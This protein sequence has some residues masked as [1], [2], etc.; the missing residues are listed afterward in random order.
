MSVM[1]KRLTLTAALL[2]AAFAAVAPGSASATVAC[3]FS[4]GALNIQSDSANDLPKIIRSGDNIVVQN[5]GTALSCGGQPTVHNTHVIAHQDVSSG[6]G[7]FIVDLGGGALAPGAINEPGN[8]DEI[9]IQVQ[10]GAGEDQV[11]VVGSDFTDSWRVGRTPNGAGINLNAQLET[12]PGATPNV[13]VDLRDTELPILLPLRGNDRVL[14]NGGPEFSGPM[15]TRV[16][17]V[18]QEGDDELTGGSGSDIFEDEGGADV[19]RGGPGDDFFLE[20]GQDVRDDIFDGGQ[21]YDSV[22]WLEY[23]R[24]MRLDLRLTGRQG[25]GAGRDV[26]AGFE[27]AGTG[28]GNDLLI[29]TDGGDELGTGKGADVILGLGGNDEM[30]GGDGF[31][32]VSYAIPPAGARQGVTLDLSKG[33]VDQDTGGAGIDRMDGV[34]GIVGSPFPDVLTGDDA[35]NRFE[36]RDGTGDR[37]TCRPGADTVVADVAGTDAANADCENIL[38]DFRPETRIEVGARSLSSDRTP[39]F[40]FAATKPGATFECSID[41]APFEACGAAYTPAPL[42]DGAHTLRVRARDMLGAVDLSPAERAFSVDATAPRLTRARLGRGSALL[43]RLSEKASVKVVIAR[44]AALSGAR[45]KRFKKA[46][47]VRLRGVKGANRHGL[48]RRIHRITTLDG[49]YRLGLVA[50][51][52]VGNRSKAVRIDIG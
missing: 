14:A 6:T 10:M 9:D 29:G 34:E 26:V 36:V 1:T 46:A 3:T 45:C 44:C 7:Q 42:A 31:D 38:L 24:D 25:T 4:S 32:S 49:R 52:R 17:L 2:T 15:L 35:G 11:V 41:G 40:R 27:S 13:D 21:G 30:H 12:G 48:G 33:Y 19:I 43:Y 8:S 39:Q 5:L 18:G 50:T 16:N 23:S 37:V 28:E 47:T 51:D 22:S 20:R